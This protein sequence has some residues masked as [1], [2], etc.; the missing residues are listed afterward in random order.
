MVINLGGSFVGL[1]IFLL[2][3]LFVFLNSILRKRVWK[4]IKE[5]FFEMLEKKVEF[6]EKIVFSLRLYYVFVVKGLV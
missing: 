1:I 4:K 5:F 2:K 6:F 3:L